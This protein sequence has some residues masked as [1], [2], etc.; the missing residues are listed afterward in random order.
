VVGPTVV[1]RAGPWIVDGHLHGSLAG[2]G[3]APETAVPLFVINGPDAGGTFDT[4]M[5]YAWSFEN[6]HASASM[7]NVNLPSADQSIVE[8]MITN[9]WT[10][11]IEGTATYMGRAPTAT[12]DPT[13]SAYPTSVHFAFGFAAPSAYINCH[14][15]EIGDMDIPANWGLRPSATGAVRAQITFHTDHS[16]W[17]T[18]L[19]EGTPL[20]FDA[21][22]ARVPDF[23]MV[24][25]HMLGMGDFMG[26]N[27]AALTDRTGMPVLDR[28]D[29]TTGYMPDMGIPPVYALNGATGISDLRDWFAFNTRT[30]GHLNSDGLC[31]VSPTGPLAY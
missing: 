18:A 30:Q 19:V 25:S 12:V 1:H 24:G 14:N 15:P 26:V 29:Q 3:G 17:D 31:L 10:H 20:R 2:A 7:I 23:G 6:A 11:Y 8:Q 28:A 21:Y 9:Q 22:A 4:T 5:Q 16:F 13:F 27:P